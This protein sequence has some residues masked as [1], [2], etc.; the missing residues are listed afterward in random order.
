MLHCSMQ[1][2]LHSLVGERKDCEELEPRPKEDWIFVD[3]KKTEA[4]KHQL[5]WSASLGK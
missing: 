2:V 1:R 4:R 5:E 3:K